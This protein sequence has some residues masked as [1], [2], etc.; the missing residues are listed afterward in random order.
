MDGIDGTLRL[1][2]GL[3]QPE[4]AGANAPDG[5]QEAA[6]Q[7]ESLLATLL[8]KE[9]RAALPDGF[10]GGG[11]GS[12]VYEGWLDQHLGA[13]LADGWDLDLAGMVRVGI[14]NKVDSLAAG[15]GGG[16]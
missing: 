2:A 14:E 16:Q 3:L 13:A 9:L 4:R 7:F 10:F 6:E 11:A 1:E 5:S 12:D 15:E 8:V